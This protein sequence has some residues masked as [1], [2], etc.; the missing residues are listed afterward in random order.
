MA[1]CRFF[2]ALNQGENK[3]PEKEN[4][5]DLQ[6][7][8]GDLGACVNLISGLTGKYLHLKLHAGYIACMV[9]TIGSIW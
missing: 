9:D 8:K 4:A 2:C 7:Q 3:G 5:L 1:N 6:P